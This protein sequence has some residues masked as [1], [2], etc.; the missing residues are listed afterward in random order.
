MVSAALAGQEFCGLYEKIVPSYT[1]FVSGK[2]KWCHCV[3][4]CMPLQVL[5]QAGTSKKDAP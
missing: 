3:S 1:G 4:H 2:I 5:Q